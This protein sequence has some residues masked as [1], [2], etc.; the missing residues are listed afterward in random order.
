MIS[1]SSL[2]TINHFANNFRGFNKKGSGKIKQILRNGF[3]V[4]FTIEKIKETL[5]PVSLKR[6]APKHAN[7]SITL[8]SVGQSIFLRRQS[9]EIDET[10]LSHHK[11]VITQVAVRLGIKDSAGSHIIS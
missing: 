7:I 5:K 1:L 4:T 11:R 9:L 8:N 2:S 10:G 6:V 3:S